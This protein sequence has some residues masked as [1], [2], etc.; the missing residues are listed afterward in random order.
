MNE[1]LLAILDGF[2]LVAKPVSCEPHG[3]G[4]INVTF[5]ASN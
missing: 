4:H 2:R 5:F 1:H 3:S